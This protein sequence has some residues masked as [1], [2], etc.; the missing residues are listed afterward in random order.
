GRG[1][2][3]NVANAN[4]DT[5]IDLTDLGFIQG[6]FKKEVGIPFVLITKAHVTPNELKVSRGSLKFHTTDLTFSGDLRQGQQG[7]RILLKMNKPIELI[8]WKDFFPVAKIPL[9]GQLSWNGA[10]SLPQAESFSKGINWMDLAFDGQLQVNNLRGRLPGKDLVV[11]R[12]DSKVDFGQ[13][14]VDVRPSFLKSAEYD[15]KFS[16]AARPLGSSGRFLS[17]AKFLSTNAWGLDFDLD[18]KSLNSKAVDPKAA[19]LE[20]KAA[21]GGKAASAD[22]EAQD[23]LSFLQ[24]KY[25]KESNLNLK[26]KI[27]SGQLGS[28]S[29][30]KLSATLAWQN[31]N[32]K[33]S[34]FSA[35][36]LSGGIKGSV[37]INARPFYLRNEDPQM[38]STLVVSSLDLSELVDVVKPEMKGLVDGKAS[39]RVVLSSQ[40]LDVDRLMNRSKGRVNVSIEDGYFESFKVLSSEINTRIKQ[41]ALNKFLTKEAQNENCIRERFK[42]R[43]DFSIEGGAISLAPS[44]FDFL[45]TDSS[46]SMSGEI[47]KDLVSDLKGNFLA[48]PRCLRGDV[49]KCLG[50]GGGK[51]KVPFNI[52]GPVSEASAKVD[53]AQLSNQ[54]QNCVKTTVVKKAKAKIKDEVKNNA[55][56][57][58]LKEKAESTLK[59]IFQG[60]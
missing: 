1:K 11:D 8:H 58:Q 13:G 30:E 52:K 19:A 17:F 25:V 31:Q 21:L 29:F 33:L 60:P 6:S 3:M 35:N 22:T 15:L 12:L 47:S 23:L 42:S 53:V 55:K 24:N 36:L 27:G 48:G 9:Q 4:F 26:V 2:G 56:V 37:E 45:Q 43:I 5:N 34:S 39:G 20:K 7:S 44:D 18:L 49:Q 14:R 16:G 38:R 32:L 54:I 10:V 46:L 50:V 28:F 41:S 51:A 57:K 59:S 40:G